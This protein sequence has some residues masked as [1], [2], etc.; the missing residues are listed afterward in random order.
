MPA[1]SPDLL[2]DDP[3]LTDAISPLT[4]VRT[5]A[6]TRP[7]LRYVYN[8]AAPMTDEDVGIWLR[9]LLRQAGPHSL[10]KVRFRVLQHESD[11]TD[12]NTNPGPVWA[13]PTGRTYA[14]DLMVQINSTPPVDP[15]SQNIWDSFPEL[16]Q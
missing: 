10:I 2:I 3:D 13:W 4:A 16:R 14:K 1:E 11:A 7:A 9:F 8:P 15:Y 12:R 6:P 5:Y